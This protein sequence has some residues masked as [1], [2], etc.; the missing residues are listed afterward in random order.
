MASCVQNVVVRAA[1][2][3]SGALVPG[4][5]LLTSVASMSAKEFVQA[6]A[7]GA[8]TT[9]RTAEGRTALFQAEFHA[10]RLADSMNALVRNHAG[11]TPSALPASI[12]V[13]DDD[14]FAED[15]VM[16]ML[17][18]LCAAGR[19][20]MM[21]GRDA[22]C[23]AATGEEVPT[24][25]ELKVVV[26]LPSAERVAHAHFSSMPPVPSPPV[27]VE[28]RPQGDVAAHS[29]EAKSTAWVH[30]RV[31][32]ENAMAADANEVICYAADGAAV[33]GLSSNV[34]VVTADGDI[35]TAPDSAVLKGSMRALILDL[36]D[37]EGI[38]IVYGAPNV[39]DAA[40]WRGM[41][42]S[43]TSR[44]AL[45]VDQLWVFDDLS[46]SAS[47]TYTWSPLDPTLTTLQ[48]A[49]NAHIATHSMPF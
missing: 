27:V 39:A 23:G 40:T 7:D 6:A 37:E 28:L 47:A 13:A 21:D 38:P 12:Y 17:L 4:S 26:C 8:Y 14:A 11:A 20:A 3:A 24:R 36:A 42:I 2:T 18:A 5:P 31:V 34:F 45:P 30:D 9:A 22:G 33:E 15:D 35:L 41:L 49:V 19:D 25:G 29:V 48:N 16:D 43:S 46:S 1:L 44:C 32:F 10:S